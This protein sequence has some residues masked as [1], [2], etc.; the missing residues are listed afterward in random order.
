[1]RGTPIVYL[2]SLAAALTL[3][4]GSAVSAQLDEPI[5]TAPPPQFDDLTMAIIENDLDA[6]GHQRRH[7]GD[8]DVRLHGGR[9]AE[10]D[11]RQEGSARVREPARGRRTSSWRLAMPARRATTSWSSAAETARAPSA[12]RRPTR[13]RSSSTSTSPC[14]ASPA[15]DGPTRRAPARVAADAIPFNYMAVDFDT[16]EAAYLAG[17]IAAAA[18][19]D[20]TPGHHQRH[21]RLPRLQSHHRGL[22]A[23]RQVGQAGHRR[24]AGLPR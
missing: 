13:R 14:P 21:G 9:R 11:R 7:H 24:G 12:S 2:M 20:D 15:M 17:M 1:M 3:L 16:D 6:A 22:R 8:R 5:A 4:T 23:G 18:S 19:R 10:S